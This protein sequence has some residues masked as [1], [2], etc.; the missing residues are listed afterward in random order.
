MEQSM[1]KHVYA[2]HIGR[3]IASSHYYLLIAHLL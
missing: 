3:V 2:L 1:L